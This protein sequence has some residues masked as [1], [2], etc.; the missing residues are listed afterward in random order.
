MIIDF[1][2]GFGGDNGGGNTEPIIIIEET[3]MRKIDITQ[4]G[5]FHPILENTNNGYIQGL[6]LPEHYT[7]TTTHFR[8]KVKNGGGFAMGDTNLSV[9]YTYIYVGY[10]RTYQRYE[11][12]QDAEYLDVEFEYIGNNTWKTIVN[13][14]RQDLVLDA[15]PPTINGIYCYY[16]AFG[17]YSDVLIRHTSQPEDTEWGYVILHEDNTCDC[18][19]WNPNTNDFDI[20]SQNIYGGTL[21]CSDKCLGFSEVNV[22]STFV[23]PN[24][25]KFS[26]STTIPPIDTSNVVDFSKM[27]YACRT[28]TTIPNIN[29]SKATNMERM[30]EECN[31]LTSIPQLDTSNVTNMHNMFYWCN[32]I[33]TIPPLDTS[34]VTNTTGMFYNCNKL[35]A[36]SQLDVRKVTEYNSDSYMFRN[37]KS[38]VD[39]GGL[40]GLK[41][42]IDLSE[43]NSLSRDSAINIMTLAEDVT[44]IT[45]VRRIKFSSQ[46]LGRLTE[47][48]IAIGTAKGWMIG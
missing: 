11:P 13:G 14:V 28:I 48:D 22:N 27:F 23:V 4:N 45:D 37:C 29:T 38:L 16:P 24:G 30:F 8:V 21:T 19:L 31:A 39:F 7:L 3:P 18:K 35:T 26:T 47:E 25:M 34:N 40:L 6:A 44:S 41:Y 46:T 2:K 12:P 36:L 43:C 42:S 1:Y 9:N 15:P 5:N 20:Y 10:S 32:S 33:T 17:E